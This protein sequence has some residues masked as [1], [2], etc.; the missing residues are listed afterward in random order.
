MDPTSHPIWSALAADIAAWTQPDRTQS[1]IPIAIGIL[2]LQGTG[3]STLVQCL[4][5]LLQDD[6]GLTAVCLSL[7]DLYLPYADRQKLREEDPRLIWRGPPGTHDIYLGLQV[8]EQLR[9]QNFPVSLPQFDKSAYLGQGDRAE[10][11]EI[12]KADVIFLEG[13]FV[14]TRP[15]A[16][17]VFDT[18]PPPVVTAA[19]RDFARDMNRNLHAYLPLWEQLDRL[20]LLN[21]TDYRLSIQWRQEAEAKMRATGKPGMS[22]AD[23]VE[24]VEYFW[25]ALHPELFVLPLKDEPQWVD[26]VIDIDAHHQPIAIYQPK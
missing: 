12:H 6:W 8:M 5:T 9:S 19:D 4:K 10:P 1:P 11:L 16:P 14:G 23:I 15:V 24:F 25:K 18:A 21:P 7:D 26:R 3:K 17:F 22:D 20:I 2:A 13:W